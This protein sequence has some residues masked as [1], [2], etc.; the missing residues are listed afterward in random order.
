MLE[1]Q[2]IFRDVDIRKRAALTEALSISSI[3]AQ[4]L[5]AR[6]ITTPLQ[7]QQWLAPHQSIPHDPYAIPDMELAVDR[8]HQAVAGGERICFYG[9]YDVDGMAAT[10]LY[11]TYFRS[12]GANVSAYIPDRRQEGYGLNEA[13]LRWLQREGVTLVVTSDCGTTAHREAETARQLGLDLIITDHHQVDA[14]LPPALAILN[15]HRSDSHYPFL[16]LCSGGLAYKVVQA[17]EARYGGGGIDP[18]SLLDLTALATVAD[19][20]PLQDENRLLV[21]EGLSLLSRGTRCGIRALKQVAGIAGDC[22]TESVAFRLAPRLNAAGRLAHAQ[23]GVHLLT[24]TSESEA[25]AGAE[26][27]ERLN[28]LRQSIEQETTAEAVALLKEGPDLPALVVWASHWHLGVVGIVAARLVDRFHR[29]AIVLAVNEQG[30]GKGSARSIPGFDLY[31]ALSE[32]RDVLEAYGGH[33]SAAGLTIKATRLEDFRRR[34]ADVAGR[35]SGGAPSLPLLHVD[36]EVNL[37]DI[38]LKL[39]RE[40]TLL[41]PFGAGNPEPTLAVRNLM[42]LQTRV[43]GDKHLKLTVRHGNSVPFD[44]IGFRMG[45]AADLG[46]SAGRTVDLAFVPERNSWNGLD[47]IQL[48]IRDLKLRGTP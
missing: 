22:T 3:T 4:I 27:L 7:A 15:P 38:N 32:C 13:A 30:I 31:Q 20:V 45:S 42:V 28:R 46:L 10:S 48:R 35:W 8:L 39:L 2:W 21:R 24:T 5:V 6:G 18:E 41:H 14:R 16:G 17:Y 33:P 12:L 40:F 36:A 9:D 23:V 1:K 26:E 37:V 11:L 43:V 25:K 47:R 19:V 44:S 29:P 34:F